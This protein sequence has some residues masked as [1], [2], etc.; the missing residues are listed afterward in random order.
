M[1]S[2]KDFNLMIDVFDPEFVWRSKRMF[3]TLYLFCIAGLYWMWTYNHLVLLVPVFSYVMSIIYGKRGILFISM[4]ISDDLFRVVSD[5]NLDGFRFVDNPGRFF[6]KWVLD[7][8]RKDI[9]AVDHWFYHIRMVTKEKTWFFYP[10]TNLSRKLTK[11]VEFVLNRDEKFHSASG[12]KAVPGN[13]SFGRR[14][15]MSIVD[16]DL[17]FDD[18]S[19]APLSKVR[20]VKG[21]YWYR[22]FRVAVQYVNEEGGLL[23]GTPV[24]LSYHDATVAWE[25][26]NMRLKHL[27]Y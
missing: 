20:F 24:E 1:E 21:E 19:L 12:K 17:F 27:E 23:T 11:E 3:L 14:T 5:K 10:G 16:E 26:I 13:V 6:Q 8:P 9:L 4:Y 7:I 22:C 18:G 2:S 15:T 25:T